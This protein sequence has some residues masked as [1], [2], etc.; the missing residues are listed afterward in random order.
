MYHIL[1]PMLVDLIFNYVQ[2]SLFD[3][4]R[5]IN[6]RGR[7][8]SMQGMTYSVDKSHSSNISLCTYFMFSQCESDILNC[9][10]QNYVL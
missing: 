4:K 9:E 2:K 6:G 5:G 8:P 7:N 1:L 3:I 10:D